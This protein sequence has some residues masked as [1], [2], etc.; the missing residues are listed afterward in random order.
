LKPFTK[1][2][3]WACSGDVDRLEEYYKNGG[4]LNERYNA[5]GSDHSLIAGALRNKQY[6][7]VD[8]L[9]A[10]G[11]TFANDGERAE[12]ADY[13]LLSTAEKLTD[14]YRY[15]NKNLTGKQYELF[16]ELEEIVKT[17]RRVKYDQ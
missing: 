2:W 8:Y 12:Y 6:K 14:Y 11:V 10:V 17:L 5:F 16:E 7:T 15:H 1:V 4:D 9:L 13:A 3:I